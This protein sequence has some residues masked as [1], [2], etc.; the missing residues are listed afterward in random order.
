MKTFA[1]AL[2]GGG[3]RGLAH[4]AVIEALD[5]MGVRPAAIAGTSIGALVGAAY[6]A[7]F[8]G[9]DL[10]RHVIDIAHNRPEIMRRLVAARAGTLAELFTA[11]LSQA[12]LVDGEKFCAQFLPGEMPDDFS[13]LAIPLTVMATDL[14]RRQEAP[15]S[16]GPLRAALAASIAIPGLFRPVSI[17]GRIMIDGGATNPLPF[18]RLAGLADVIVAVDVFGM[19][20]DRDDMPSTWECLYTTVLI[21]GG[22]IVAAKHRHV[23]P[24]LTIRPNVVTFRTM[25][26]AQAS[27]ILRAADAIKL[28]VKESLGALLNAAP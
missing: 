7:G 17:D 10:R 5:E 9:K 15:L 6:A 28:E 20:S 11:G 25:D 22:A 24:D 19:P 26:F 12:T 18:D 23:A 13:A 8:S 3:A 27:A 14:H 21:M 4:I 2:G 1:L 16:S